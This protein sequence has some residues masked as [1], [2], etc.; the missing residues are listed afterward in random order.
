MLGEARVLSAPEHDSI[1]VSGVIPADLELFRDHFPDFPVVPGVLS[2]ELMKKAADIF[3]HSLPGTAGT[4]LRLREVESAKFAA[5]LKPGDAWEVKLVF[6]PE[7]LERIPCHGKLV[8]EGRAAVSASLVF[9]CI[10]T[11]QPN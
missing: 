6:S 10:K 5:Y 1:H 3:W 11:R 8:H 2:L 4:A 9:E 7:G